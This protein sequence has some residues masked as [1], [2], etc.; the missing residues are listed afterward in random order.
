MVGV[1]KS[2]EEISV[3]EER[4]K[5]QAMV[6]QVME[7]DLQRVHQQVRPRKVHPQR[8]TQQRAA[9]SL[10]KAVTVTAVVTA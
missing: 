10:Q 9:P 8:R 1:D 3:E 2:L 6:V 7:K 5:D 4:K